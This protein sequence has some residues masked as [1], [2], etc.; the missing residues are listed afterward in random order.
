MFLEA[1]EKQIGSIDT[2]L[3][4]KEIKKITDFLIQ[5]I[6]QFGDT[7]SAK[8]VVQKICHKEISAEPIIRYYKKKYEKSV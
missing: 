6:Y 4:K 5:K 7:L 1:I 8:E 2:L 3:E